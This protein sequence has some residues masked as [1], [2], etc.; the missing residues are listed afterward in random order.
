MVISKKNVFVFYA[1]FAFNN[2]DL[3]KKKDFQFLR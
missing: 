3:K 1:N 2:D